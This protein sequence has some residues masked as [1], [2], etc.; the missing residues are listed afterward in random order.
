MVVFEPGPAFEPMGWLP[1][2]PAALSAAWSPLARAGDAGTT[3]EG[4]RGLLNTLTLAPDG[5]DFEVE[6]QLAGIDLP[7]GVAGA[8]RE[9]IAGRGDAQ[10]AK[11]QLG[12]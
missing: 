9:L 2:P 3:S 4:T 11:R 1:R 7:L 5:P 6:Q 12:R 10:T 8:H